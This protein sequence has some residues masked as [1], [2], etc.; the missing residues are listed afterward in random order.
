[1]SALVQEMQCPFNPNHFSLP[2]FQSEVLLRPALPPAINLSYMSSQKVLSRLSR[3]ADEA[4][5]QV[6]V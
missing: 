5:H 3:I 4:F 1:M 6:R 2:L